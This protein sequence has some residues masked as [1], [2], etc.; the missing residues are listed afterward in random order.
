MCSLPLLL[1][2]LPYPMILCIFR[3]IPHP[4]AKWIVVLC[5]RGKHSSATGSGLVM[6]I[7]QVI[8]VFCVN[9]M[10]IPR[11]WGI[12]WKGFWNKTRHGFFLGC[13]IGFCEKLIAFRVRNLEKKPKK[14]WIF[15]FLPTKIPGWTWRW[16]MKMDMGKVGGF[17]NMFSFSSLS[18]ERWSN[19][20]SKWDQMGGEK[21]TNYPPVN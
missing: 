16:I 14:T 17:P 10:Q 13:R 3:G 12:F 11:I 6:I 4:T 2:D 1:L 21:T 9:S 5:C 19:L 20:T 15:C 8:G 18:L 7:V